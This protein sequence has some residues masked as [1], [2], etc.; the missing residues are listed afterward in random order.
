MSVRGGVGGGFGNVI[1][2]GIR[3]DMGWVGVGWGWV[4]VDVAV[5]EGFGVVL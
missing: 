5:R 2:G 1:S 4:V 3:D